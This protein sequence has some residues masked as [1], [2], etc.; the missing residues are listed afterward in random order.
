MAVMHRSS[1]LV[2]ECLVIFNNWQA[3]LQLISDIGKD[4]AVRGDFVGK[5]TTPA[6]LSEYV[7]LVTPESKPL[8]LYHIIASNSW[9]HVLVFVGSRKDA[10]RLSLLL[11]YLGQKSFKVAEISSSLSRPAREKVLAKFAAGKIDVLVSSDAL[12][13]GMDIEGVDYVILYSA[14]KSI[15]NYI[16]RVG[17][18]GRAGKPGTSVT[19]LQD[20]QVA[21][22]NE[23]LHSASKGDLQKMDIQQ[24]KLEE[25]EDAYTLAL[26]H[27][28]GHLEREEKQQLKAK[29]RRKK[30]D[31][32]IQKYR[33]R[34]RRFKVRKLKK[35]DKATTI[36]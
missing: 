35:L 9:Q 21:S 1:V 4:E 19:F 22:F 2:Y 30:Q 8:A 24:S 31:P 17:R 10:H 7:C 29:K 20:S 26:E 34:K 27:L 25:L 12:A 33:E 16:H 14:P 28:K 32:L 11:S 13:R 18:T 5:F 3:L 6:E 23:M 15:K 36:G